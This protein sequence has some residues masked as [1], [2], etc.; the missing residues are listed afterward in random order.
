MPSLPVE[1]FLQKAK[2]TTV[3]DVRSPAEYAHAH[4][5]G[6]VNLP[7]FDN[8]E[9]AQVG[10]L[11]KKTGRDAAVLLGLEI[12]GPKLATFVRQANQLATNQEVLV[13]CW[14]G[15]MRSGSM[16]WLLK[17]AGLETN[18]LEGGYKAYR[19][20]VLDSFERHQPIIVLGGKTGSGK[21]EILHNLAKM[22]EQVIDLEGLAHH[23]GSSF[24]AIGQ[25]PQPSSE[26]FENLIQQQWA[27]LD[28]KRPVWIE[29]ESRNVG[30]CSVP[31]QLWTKMRAAKVFFVDVP[32]NRRIER[33]VAEYACFEHQLLV[34]ATNRIAKRLGGQHHQAAIAALAQQ[35]YATVADIT[36]TYYDKSYLHGLSQRDPSL[37]TEIMIADENVA[38]MA[39][40]LIDRA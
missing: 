10:T 31:M 11:Y 30:S 12:V 4:I 40:Q 3:I 33:L 38:Q 15:G 18:T 14:R 9:R 16:A 19:N 37:V 24:G 17:T 29:D 25:Q 1:S 7:L 26:Q 5:P 28:P 36:L 27:M 35:D 2:T 23:K 32:K 13:H 8:N 22:G 34:E 20:H 6:A 21:T 39:A